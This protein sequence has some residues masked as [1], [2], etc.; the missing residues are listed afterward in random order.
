MLVP[1]HH[2]MNLDPGV[3]VGPL[4]GRAGSLQGLESHTC[5]LGM[6]GPVLGPLVD[7]AVSRGNWGL[8]G[9]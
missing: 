6:R 5:I 2:G 9:S 1:T 4:V 8:R 3:S 7:R